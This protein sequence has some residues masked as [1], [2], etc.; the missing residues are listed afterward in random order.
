MAATRT[1]GKQ[2]QL[3]SSNNTPV[4]ICV[5]RLVIVVQQN[6]APP[7][8]VDMLQ[9]LYMQQVHF[10]MHAEGVTQEQ[11]AGMIDHLAQLASA[12]RLQPCACSNVKM[13]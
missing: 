8:C 9:T 13:A 11:C 3:H 1:A 6:R 10:T 4:I 5:P 7:N 2:L 12:Y